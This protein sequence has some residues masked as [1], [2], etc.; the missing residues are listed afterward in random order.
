LTGGCLS[1]PKPAVWLFAIKPGATAVC[2]NVC[3]SLPR[4]AIGHGQPDQPVFPDAA[5]WPGPSCPTGPKICDV[6]V[7]PALLEHGA[8]DL[9]DAEVAE[10][11]WFAGRPSQ[12]GKRF[13]RMTQ[14]EL[15]REYAGVVDQD[16]D[17]AELGRW[18]P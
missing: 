7:R 11:S 9:L 5:Y 10:V 14:L 1:S 12:S 13:M 4:E 3:A 2:S 16:V 17:F 18:P 8:D 6:D 15:G